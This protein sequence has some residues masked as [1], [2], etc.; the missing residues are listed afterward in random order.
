M[1]TRME[2]ADRS[3][4]YSGAARAITSAFVT[5]LIRDLLHFLVFT[6]LLDRLLLQ[7]DSLLEQHLLA[8]ATDG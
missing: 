4:R 8:K 6:H 5:V 1:P 7:T 3:A 2:F